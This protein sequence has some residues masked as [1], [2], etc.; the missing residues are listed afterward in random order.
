MRKVVL[1][2]S[3]LFFFLS[4]IFLRHHFSIFYFQNDI[5][6]VAVNIESKNVGDIYICFDKNCD[7]MKYENKLYFYELNQKNPMFYNGAFNDIEF[8]LDN[9]YNDFSSISIFYNLNKI[10]H[11]SKKDMKK[12]SFNEIEFQNKKKYSFEIK[13]NKANNKTYLQKAAIYFESL[14]YN[15]YFH[16]IGYVLIIV[17]FIKYQ[18]RFNFKIKYGI[19]WILFLA[20][21]LRLSHIDYISLWNDELYVLCFISDLGRGFN[22]ERTFLDPG[23]PPLFFVISNIWLYFFNKSIILIR[24]LP[25][26]IGLVQ[27]YSTYFV[28]DKIFNKKIAL[29]SAF[30]S[31]I[32]ILFILESNEIRSYILSMT[33]I[34][35]GVYWFYKLKNNFTNKNLAIYFLISALL[36][37]LHYYCILFVLANFVLGLFLFKN[38]KIKFLIANIIS[39]ITFIPYFLITFMKNS[40]NPVFNTWIEKPSLITI[41]HHIVFYFGNIFWFLAV[42]IFLIFV[43]KKLEENKKQFLNYTLYLIGF[44]FI[45]AFLI[46]LFVKPMLFERYFI[47]FLPL[48]VVNTSIFLCANY[49]TKFQSLIVCLLLLVSINIPKYENFNLFSNI[50]SMVGYSLNDYMQYED[51]YKIYLVVPDKAEYMKYFR[52]FSQD[53][54]IV[55][56]YGVRED[57]DLIQFYLEKINYKKGEKAIFYL[58]EICINSKIKYSKNLNIRKIKTTIVPVYKIYID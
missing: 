10:F 29:I 57:V 15:W 53:R 40:I 44:I 43:Y 38:N 30:L 5:G 4:L 8:V 58:P 1:I 34:L 47:I 42:I 41:Y 9:N 36:I 49:K 19:L 11:L 50:N 45:V 18:N 12:L 17:Y 32:N 13:F 2:L 33:L 6:R 35:W 16:L 56:Q 20:L 7:L 24:L 22:F 14:F 39:F 52:N 46:S 28:V 23:N 48:L 3:I 26:L 31:S 25:C 21:L 37:N 55:S 54:V 27:I 51:E